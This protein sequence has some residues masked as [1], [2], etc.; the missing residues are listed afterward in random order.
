M[1]S[2]FLILM[3]FIS[4]LRMIGQEQHFFINDSLVDFNVEKCWSLT[5]KFQVKEFKNFDFEIS[6]IEI[7]NNKLI[8]YVDYGGGCGNVHLKLYIDDS[9]DLLNEPIINLFPEFIDHDSCKAIRY[10]K[11]CF[12]V[13]FLLKNRTRPLLLQIGTHT[14]IITI[15]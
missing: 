1:K 15:E 8:L 5:K 14:K 11:I 4:T 10:R 2:L 6:K 3:F 9:Y 12:D 7:I 13:E